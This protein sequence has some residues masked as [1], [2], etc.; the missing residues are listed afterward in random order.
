MWQTL[1]QS[2]YVFSMIVC[3]AALND[4]ECNYVYS[5]GPIALD[6]CLETRHASIMYSCND[7]KN[8]IISKT[9]ETCDT[10]N[11]DSPKTKTHP[12]LLDFYCDGQTATSNSSD[13]CSYFNLKWHPN[14]TRCQSTEWFRTSY[15]QDFCFE[16][17]DGD[18]L[19][20]IVIIQPQII[21]F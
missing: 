16:T 14:D 8:G 17:R 1:F 19:N 12:E 11:C 7:E 13:V 6:V 20:F 3:F 10:C 9:W 5:D 21:L 18:M 15:I 2:V 4:E